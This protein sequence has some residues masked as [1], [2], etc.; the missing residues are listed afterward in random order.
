ML[1]PGDGLGLRKDFWKRMGKA[2]KKMWRQTSLDGIGHRKDD[3]THIYNNTL[4]MGRFD[5]VYIIPAD[6]HFTIKQS[7]IHFC[8]T[9]KDLFLSR[10]K[11]PIPRV[12]NLRFARGFASHVVKVFR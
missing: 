9:S 3:S 4:A 7:Y 2:K 6:F 11:Y 5:R 10:I 12:L 1:E 8:Y